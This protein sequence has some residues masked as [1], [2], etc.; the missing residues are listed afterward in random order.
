MKSRKK[1]RNAIIREFFEK[2]R[3][4]NCFGSAIEVLN[5]NKVEPV[6]LEVVLW[7]LMTKIR[8]KF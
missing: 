3:V 5:E 1:N 4:E 8:G 2:E 6:A 7:E